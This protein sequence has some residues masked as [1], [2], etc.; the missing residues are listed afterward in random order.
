MYLK[1]LSVKNT[2]AAK[3]PA[4]RRFAVR[5]R[6]GRLPQPPQYDRHVPLRRD[7]A[8]GRVGQPSGLGSIS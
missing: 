6:P 5:H 2:G 3:L 8:A 4:G 7:D 1:P